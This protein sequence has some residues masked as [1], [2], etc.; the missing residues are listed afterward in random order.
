MTLSPK[1]KKALADYYESAKKIT[2]A[3]ALAD[4]HEPADVRT[5]RIDRLLG[6]FTQFCKY[7]FPQFCQSEFG[8]FHKA[9]AKAIANDPNIF[10]V[11]EWPRAHSKSVFA[12]VL[13]P[14]YLKASNDMNGMIVVSSNQAKAIG[15][16]IDIQVQ[17]R[18]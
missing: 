5:A 2:S 17:F 14:L 8:W 12:D 3:V 4:P 18:K 9:A 1:D 15:L 10:A 6:N 13:M 11:V 16:L 7:Y